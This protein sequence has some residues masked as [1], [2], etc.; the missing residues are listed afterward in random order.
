MSNGNENCIKIIEYVA[1]A[2]YNDYSNNV[3]EQYDFAVFFHCNDQ[4]NQYATMCECNKNG[5]CMIQCA[6]ACID[7]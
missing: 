4:T 7:P 6:H 5:A 3:N 2:M 1:V